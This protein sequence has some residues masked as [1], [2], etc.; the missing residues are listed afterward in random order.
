MVFFIIKISFLVFVHHF[1]WSEEESVNELLS[2]YEALQPFHENMTIIM[3]E[4][5]CKNTGKSSK[6]KKECWIEAKW[7]D[8]SESLEKL[9]LDTENTLDT[10]NPDF[11][12]TPLGQKYQDL[13]N[14]MNLHKNLKS[15]STENS[16][17]DDDILYRTQ[18][19]ASLAL[20]N[21][22]M[23]K[24]VSSNSENSIALFGNHLEQ[25]ANNNKTVGSSFEDDLFSQALKT[26][27]QTRINFT[28]QTGEDNINTQKFKQTFLDKF[29]IGDVPNPTPRGIRRK[30]DWICNKKDEE[31]ITNLI[32]EAINSANTKELVQHPTKLSHQ[33]EMCFTNSRKKKC[34]NTNIHEFQTTPPKFAEEGQM[35]SL[36][37]PVIVADINERIANLNFILE[38]YNNQK[39]ELEE[40]WALENPRQ[41]KYSNLPKKRKDEY[42]HALK[43]AKFNDELK[44]LKKIFFLEYKQELALLHA[45]GAGALLQTDAVRNKSNFKEIEKITSKGLGLLG[46]EEAELTHTEGFPLL[47]PINEHTARLAVQERFQRMDQ[48]IKNLLSDQRNKHKTDQQYLDR[49]QENPSEDVKKWYNDQRFERLSNLILFNPQILSSVLINNPEYS[50][51]LCTTASRIAKDQRFREMLK[52]GIFIGSAVGAITISILT[53]GAGAPASLT[54]IISMAAGMGVAT[55]DFTIRISEVNRHSRNQEDLLNAYLSQTGDHQSIEDIRKEWKS[56]VKEQFHAGW[57][58]ALGT[59][60][61]FRISSSIKKGAF[62]KQEVP[63]PTLRV[64]NDQLPRIITENNQYIRPIQDLLQKHP[65]RS[66]QRLLNSVKR[67]PPDQQRIILDS[68]SKISKQ[69]SFN[70]TA[71][72]REIK[73]SS[74]KD[75]VVKILRRWA[76]CVS[77]RAKAGTRK[78]KDSS[79]ANSII[80]SSQ[81]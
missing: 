71:F 52:T 28:K 34:V 77:C 16:V 46:F 40:K 79:D 44:R 18:S 10:S 23:C 17:I 25:I 53:A 14:L 33:E 78:Q 27:I 67:L 81:L 29:C 58:L 49:L 65:L 32:K 37:T 13:K 55:A 38:D 45:S 1:S 7:E 75:N 5:K 50:S 63:T 31:I 11:I 61:I 36:P 2:Q 22:S 73:K 72:T 64:Q 41:Q 26:S 39:K 42:E 80:E 48:H 59:F 4:E 60:D 57:A 54:S 76:V 9:L 21:S 69:D 6:F 51:I 15:C 12:Q 43:F 47:Q 35:D 8:H 68:F 20:E 70:L 74:S 3:P 66:V 56:K 62:A 19:N 24:P 30:K